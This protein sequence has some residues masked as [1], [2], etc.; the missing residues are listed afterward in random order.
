MGDRE[1]KDS[2]THDI[3]KKPFFLQDSKSKTDYSPE[4]FWYLEGFLGCFLGSY[5]SLVHTD[6][7]LAVTQR[8]A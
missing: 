8:R 1:E 5:H 3:L 6:A 4:A 7:T 2:E